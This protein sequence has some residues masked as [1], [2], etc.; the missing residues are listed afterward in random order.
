MN[1][2]FLILG[3]LAF[4]VNAATYRIIGDF[5]VNGDFTIEDLSSTTTTVPPTTTTTTTDTHTQT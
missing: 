3:L 2:L 4:Q 5:T 1:K